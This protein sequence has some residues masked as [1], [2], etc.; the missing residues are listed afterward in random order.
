MFRPRYLDNIPTNTVMLPGSTIDIISNE[1]LVQQS[2]TQASDADAA[3][4]IASPP[5]GNY[6]IRLNAGFGAG[7]MGGAPG[8][9]TI[10]DQTGTNTSRMISTDFPRASGALLFATAF[11]VR[12]TGAPGSTITLGTGAFVYR[13][14]SNAGT[15]FVLNTTPYQILISTPQSLCANATGVNIAGEFG[16][17]FG[18]GTTLNRNSD[19][20]APIGGY[21][22]VQ[23]SATQAIGDGQYGIVKNMSPRNGTNSNAA[24][25]NACIPAAPT[26]DHC[27]MRMFNGFWDIFGDHT[28]QATGASNPPPAASTESGYMLLV[29]S[30]NIP[31][32]VYQQQLNNLCP[33][34]YYEFSAWVKNVCSVCGVNTLG[35]QTYLPGVNP[36]LTFVLDGVDRYST[37]EVSYIASNGWVKKGFVFTTG[38]AQ[39]SVMFAIRTNSQ[40]GG[41]NDWAIDDISVATCLPNMTYTPT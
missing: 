1:G 17:T 31:S 9:H 36:N 35:S 3:T 34:T 27:D 12:V 14:V 11:R 23:A 25:Q 37:G 38:P 20:A 30:D 21:T 19:L 26:N 8:A 6:N 4:Y 16:G 32:I 7:F 10:A 15:Q 40:G 22:Y 28:G 41:G 2:Y 5:A 13:T 24:R 33:N 39:T 29:N 18:S